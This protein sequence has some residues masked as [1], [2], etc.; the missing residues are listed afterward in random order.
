[1]A[2]GAQLSKGL[3]WF[4]TRQLRADAIVVY[5]KTRLA[6]LQLNLSHHVR[7]GGNGFTVLAQ[8][9]SHLLQDAADFRLLFFQQTN[10]V[11]IL[12]NGF[13]RLNEHGLSAGAC[14]V[15]DAIDALALL[16][17]YGDDEALAANG[18]EF[19]LHCAAFRQPTEIAAQRLLDGTLLLFHVATDARELCRCAI[20][21]RAVRL[22]LVA[23][24]AQQQG[25]VGDLLRERQHADPVR[26]YRVR[27]MQR[28]LSPF[29]G[30]IH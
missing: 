18:D 26:L 23:E 6:D 29:R 12:L 8:A 21:Q 14:A 11:I 16:R 1:M 2:R 27:R 20:V 5:G 25:E 4:R 24:V 13:Q 28:H 30:F 19:I 17:F 22:D 3:G 7:G 9:L 10:E 15:N